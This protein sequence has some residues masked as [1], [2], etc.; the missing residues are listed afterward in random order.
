MNLE[1]TTDRAGQITESTLEQNG[2]SV[3]EENIIF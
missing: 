2:S 1:E 3:K